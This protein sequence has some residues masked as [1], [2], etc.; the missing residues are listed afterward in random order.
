MSYVRRACA[1]A[2]I[3]TW[4]AVP[5]QGCGFTL[6]S[7]GHNFMLD[8]A[9]P[10]CVA[11]GK[12][13]YHTIIPGLVTDPEGDLLMTFGVMGAF[14]QPQ[15]HLQVRGQGAGGRGQGAGGRGQGAGA[16]RCVWAPVLQ[17]PAR[18]AA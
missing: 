12:R 15:G 9:H 10:N 11:P 3:T 14:M 13:P 7:R 8:P 2:A 6:Q 4:L 18:G 17:L 1:A 5:L 16:G